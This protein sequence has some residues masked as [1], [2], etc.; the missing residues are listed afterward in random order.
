MTNGAQEAGLTILKSVLVHG[1][2]DKPPL[3]GVYVMCHNSCKLYKTLESPIDLDVRT[4][5]GERTAEYKKLMLQ[6][7]SLGSALQI[8]SVTL[9]VYF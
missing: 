3:F 8:T 9:F 5:A 2:E 7:V 4:V 1:R 6:M